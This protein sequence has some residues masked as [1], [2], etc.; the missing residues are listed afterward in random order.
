MKIQFGK[1]CRGFVIAFLLVVAIIAPASD[2]T[3]LDLGFSAG[4]APGTQAGAYPPITPLL[5]NGR[6]DTDVSFWPETTVGASVWDS[7][8]N[9]VGAMGSGS[10]HVSVTGSSIVARQQCIVLPF[11]ETYLLNGFG[12]STGTITPGSYVK[13]GWEYRSAGS[14]ACTGTINASGRLLLSS[15][16]EWRQP[17]APAVI[18]V[19]DSEWTPTSTLMVYLIVEDGGGSGS[20]PDTPTAS[21]NGWFDG[22]TLGGLGDAI[23]A[24]GFD[25]S[26]PLLHNDV[27]M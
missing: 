27:E 4:D 23:F 7:T 14:Q 16:N 25:G 19:T 18:T 5:K 2:A 22:I 21:L 13:L 24:N 6:F 3:D 9:I 8:Q 20:P 10:L 17:P 1:R 12:K 26:S 15:N 11:P